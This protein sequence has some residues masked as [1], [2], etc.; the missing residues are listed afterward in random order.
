MSE[1]DIATRRFK[2]AFNN[3]KAKLEM[4]KKWL[5]LQAK[6]SVQTQQARRNSQ[7][8]VRR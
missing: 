6:G 7:K 5:A 2:E 1:L 3:E 4:Q 8:T